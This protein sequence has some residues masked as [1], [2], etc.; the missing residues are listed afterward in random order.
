M[1]FNNW[2]WSHDQRL[3]KISWFVPHHTI[4]CNGHDG[5]RCASVGHVEAEEW[6]KGITVDNSPIASYAYKYK[7]SQRKK[8]SNTKQT[9]SAL[10]HTGPA[11]IL[12]LFYLLQTHLNQL[13]FICT[14]VILTCFIKYLRTTCCNHYFVHQWSVVSSLFYCLLFPPRLGN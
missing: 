1:S 14:I 2:P 7:N 3:R 8:G 12:L 11:P 6:K 10:I 9:S 4:P 13:E 5:G